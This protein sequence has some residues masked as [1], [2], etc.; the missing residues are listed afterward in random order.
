MGA[1]RVTPGTARSRCAM[2]SKS[3]SG[4]AAAS[5]VT[6]PLKPRIEARNSLRKPPITDITMISVATP[7][8]MP[9]SEKPEITETKLSCRLA[10]R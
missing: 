6:W 4:P 9:T 8:A 3:G 5:T 1:A 7:S 10:R 2:T